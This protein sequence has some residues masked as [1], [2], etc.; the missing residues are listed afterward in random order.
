MPRYVWLNSSN[1][2][3]QYVTTLANDPNVPAGYVP[4][5]GSDGAPDSA[6]QQYVAGLNSGGY[7]AY[8]S[9]PTQATVA[10]NLRAAGARYF[11][12]NGIIGGGTG[13]K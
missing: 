13:D 8:T 3:Q 12:I 4:T 6:L 7:P 5:G 1:F 10:A 9:D 2:R 11:W